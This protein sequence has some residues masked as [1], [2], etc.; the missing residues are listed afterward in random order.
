MAGAL[1]RT[2]WPTRR[3]HGTT[4]RAEQTRTR[5]ESKRAKGSPSFLKYK[6]QRVP[7]L[8]SFLWLIRA[9]AV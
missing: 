1:Q 3:P 8:L 6:K 4:R 2:Q 5:P 7:A 9:P